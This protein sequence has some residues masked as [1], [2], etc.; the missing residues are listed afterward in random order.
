MQNPPAPHLAARATEHRQSGKSSALS[1]ES[2]CLGNQ[3]QE[4]YGSGPAHLATSSCLETHGVHAPPASFEG[5]K[6]IVR[7]R[8]DG[9]SFGFFEDPGRT[10]FIHPFFTQQVSAGHLLFREMMSE[11]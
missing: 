10:T 7:G 9:R 11:T 1:P 4:A 5:V 3:S 6:V 8:R 2:S